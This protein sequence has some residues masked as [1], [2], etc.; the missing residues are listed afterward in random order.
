MRTIILTVLGAMMLVLTSCSSTSRLTTE[1]QQKIN[2]LD[3]EL[4]ITWNDYVRKADSLLI[5]IDNIRNTNHKIN[6]Q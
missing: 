2:Q 3:Y 1:Q 4:S 5:E 6:K